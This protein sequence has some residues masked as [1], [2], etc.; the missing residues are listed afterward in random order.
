MNLRISI[1]GCGP[2]SGV[3]QIGNQWGACDPQNPRNRR[4]RPSLLVQRINSLE[5]QGEII[6][7]SQEKITSVLID[8]SPDIRMQLLGQH[9][10]QLDGVIYTHEH[11]DHTHGIDD[12]RIIAKNGKRRID[13]YMSEY[14]YSTMIQ[15]FSFYFPSPQKTLYPPILEPHIIR[16]DQRLKIEGAGGPIDILLFEQYHGENISLG[17]RFGNVAYSTD[18]NDLPESSLYALENLDLW[19]LGALR[20]R[21]KHSSHFT[22]S[23]ALNWIEQFKPK[24]A[25]LTNMNIDLDY[26]VLQRD[27]PDGIEPAYDGM[28]IEISEAT[29]G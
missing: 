13:T 25:I 7:E 16:K 27:L 12:L 3:P 21:P 14:T 1:L 4:Q 9:I 28:V 5:N 17:I 2:S 20:Y 15:R 19:I 29:K 18:L 11:A 10:S 8:T 6:S 23:D 26:E 22:I 24:R